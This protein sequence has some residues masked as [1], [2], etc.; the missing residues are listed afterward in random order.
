MWYT[1]SSFMRH[2]LSRMEEST[3][4]VDN[5]MW[6]YEM[7]IDIC[8]PRSLQGHEIVVDPSLTSDVLFL[9]VEI[10]WNGLR[11]YHT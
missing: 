8:G 2:L 9:F 4:V 5:C 6:L 11:G 10:L 3:Q 1:N 7:I